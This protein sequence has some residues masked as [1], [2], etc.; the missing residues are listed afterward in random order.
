MKCTCEQYG[1]I[2]IVTIKGEVTIDHVDQFQ[3]VIEQH[4]GRQARDFV[5]DMSAVEFVDSAGLEAMIG[6]QDRCSDV[7]GQVRLVGVGRNVEEILRIT[8]LGPRFDKHESVDLAIK[9]LQV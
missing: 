2:A 8:R 5:V 6:L 4:V 9:S 7:L 1:Q 3:N